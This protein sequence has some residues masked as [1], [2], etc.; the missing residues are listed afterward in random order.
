[1]PQR[2]RMDIEQVQENRINPLE[3]FHARDLVIPV[4][5]CGMR[6]SCQE[7]NEQ[8]ISVLLAVGDLY[9]IVKE[10]KMPHTLQI[11][12]LFSN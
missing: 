2:F 4:E 7:C 8:Q 10:Y 9:A 12:V 5:A 3:E 6:L 11:V 1:M